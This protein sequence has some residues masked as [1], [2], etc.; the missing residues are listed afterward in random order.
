MLT[1]ELNLHHRRRV[2]KDIVVIGEMCHVR[3]T[4]GPDFLEFKSQAV[5]NIFM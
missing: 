1:S 4:D 3:V 5:H 2:N